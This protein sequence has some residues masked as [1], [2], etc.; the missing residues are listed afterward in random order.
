[1][2]VVVIWLN[3]MLLNDMTLREKNHNDINTD[4]RAK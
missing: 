2:E 1:M 4:R 3:T